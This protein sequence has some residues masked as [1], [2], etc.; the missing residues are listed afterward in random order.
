MVEASSNDS[1]ILSGR[2]NCEKPERGRECT[3]WTLPSLCR[4]DREE[5]R[6]THFFP[7]LCGFTLS[8]FQLAVVGDV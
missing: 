6:R 8:R 1:G 5:S 2:S 7:A 3:G 4:G